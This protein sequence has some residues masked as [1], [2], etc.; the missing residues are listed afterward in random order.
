MGKGDARTRSGR[1]RGR[2]RGGGSGGVCSTSGFH[3]NEPPAHPCSVPLAM[4]DFEQCDPNAC[5]GKKLYRLNALR[6]LRLSEP[7]HGVVLTPSATEIV[8]P[9]DRGIVLQNG[10][11]VVDCS[12]KEL[13]AVPWRKM[14]MSAPRL[15]PLLLAANP[16]NYGRPSKLNCAE[17][18]AATLAIVGLTDDA[19]SIMAYFSWGASFFDVNRELLAGYQKCT[20]SAEIA[21]FQDKYVEAELQ[22]SEARR[23]LDLDSIDL[24][25]ARP[26]NERRGRL[27]NRREWQQPSCSE[28]EEENDKAG[29]DDNSD[30]GA[31]A[32]VS[33]ED[34]DRRE[35]ECAAADST[36][37]TA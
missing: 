25:D 3:N 27:K 35:S 8:S 33:E 11:A 13:D 10:A 2:G 4:W 6:L 17:A 16:V 21:A 12:W 5:S 19:R 23:G 34:E 22:E 26:L 20:N 24:S 32:R 18:L 30:E 14:R 9:A 1:G 28:D 37:E 36:E 15:L 29:E 31:D 7:F